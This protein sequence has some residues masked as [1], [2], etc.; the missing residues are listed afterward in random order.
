MATTTR[1]KVTVKSVK[2]N[3]KWINIITS[4]A[5]EIGIKRESNPKLSALEIK[6]GSEVEMDISTYEKDGVT[7]LFGNDPK[8]PKTAQGGNG[9][10]GFAPAKPKTHEVALQASCQLYSLSKDIPVEKVLE[11]ASKFLVWL[12]ENKQ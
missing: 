5:R 12:N 8:D 2:T 11:T 1:E 9:G 3:E 4:D 6:E 7:K 10:K